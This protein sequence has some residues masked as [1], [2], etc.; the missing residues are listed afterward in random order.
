MSWSTILAC[1]AQ[2]ELLRGADPATA[3]A[4]VLERFGDP[5][6]VARRL[7]LDAMKGKIMAQRV[8][9]GTCVLV[10]AVSLGLV[11]LLF[12]MTVDA[13]RIAARQAVEAETRAA[14]ALAREQEMLK[15]LGEM[16]EAIKH[17]RS[18][19]WNPM[20]LKLT[21]ETPDGP[22]VAGAT[23]VLTRLF[24]DPAKTIRK[25]SD[26]AGV[27]DF[28]SVQPGDYTFAIERRS[29]NWSLESNGELNVQPGSDV[30]KSIVC[31]KMPPPRVGVRVRW[32][33]PASLEKETLVL[34]AQFSFR[35]RVLASGTPWTISRPN[36]D[37]SSAFSSFVVTHSLL[38]GPSS[39]MF[40]FKNSSGPL[41][42]TIQGGNITSMIDA[43]ARLGPGDFADVLEADLEETTPPSAT[44]DFEIGTYGLSELIVLRPRQSRDVVPG[45]REFELLVA[46]R[47]PHYIRR[48]HVADKP[49]SEGD[50][51]TKTP[52][53]IGATDG[54]IRSASYVG[55][56]DSTPT[57]ELSK[58][59][60]LRVDH[61]FEAS[62]TQPNEW[63]IP[64]PDELVQAVREA[65]KAE[66]S[67]APR[68]SAGTDAGKNQG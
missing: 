58:A 41:L 54:R 18:P 8:V 9:I 30:T 32:Q 36:V 3:R 43:A 2:R 63:T 34:Y 47:A 16:S 60:W 28:G 7:W 64:L 59:Y 35:S 37:D 19:D 55:F 52:M 49:P 45:R 25:T 56:T 27:A 40:H 21:E 5:A 4:R 6:A 23:I 24:E 31:P 53:I 42:W 13:R 33:W 68:P 38:C 48:I 29:K 65:L 1:S 61:E 14:E 44:L 39:K 12:Q 66:N 20:R 22:P 67:R 50:L 17:P 62:P 11:G 26:A 57:I 51:R 10:T 46:V 15:R